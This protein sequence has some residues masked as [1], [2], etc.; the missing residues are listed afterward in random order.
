MIAPTPRKNLA[1]RCDAWF[2]ALDMRF[3]V[4]GPLSVSL[5]GGPL[6]LGGRKQRT[7][8]AVLLL[9]ANEIVA[10][11]HLVDALWGERPPPSAAES[12]DTYVYRLR[13]L[14][15]HDRLSR[16]GGGYLLRVELGELDVDEFEQLVASAGRAADAGDHSPPSIR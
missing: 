13:K 15:G 7:L 14:L 10:R 3:A 16:A 5:D 4:L 11:D 6:S 8:L 9:R 1:L 2:H 12:L